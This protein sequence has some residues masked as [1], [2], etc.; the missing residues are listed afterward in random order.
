MKKVIKKIW[1]K[2]NTNPVLG[3]VFYFLACISFVACMDLLGRISLSILEQSLKYVSININTPIDILITQNIKFFT[4]GLIVF[5]GSFLIFLIVWIMINVFY[6]FFT[7]IKENI[8]FKM[9]HGG[10]EKVSDEII[11]Y[12]KNHTKHSAMD[13]LDVEF[14]REYNECHEI[15]GDYNH[16]LQPNF[17]FN[18]V[19]VYNYYIYNIPKYFFDKTPGSLH[20]ELKVALL[21]KLGKFLGIEI[22][23]VKESV[24]C[25]NYAR[26]ETN[27]LC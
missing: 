15:P 11:D 8:Q 18:A 9:E 27:P 20:D 7:K 23:I 6:S 12:I 25:V 24:I 17:E 4:I 1:K 21:K 5:I 13:L 3:F 26:E 16:I 2:T 19:R 10:I 14:V 22:N